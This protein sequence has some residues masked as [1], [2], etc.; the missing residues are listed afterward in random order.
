[1]IDCF[2]TISK[3]IG[4]I[5]SQCNAR[6]ECKSRHQC[7]EPDKLLLAFTLKNE[8]PKQE[9]A[10]LA[11]DPIETSSDSVSRLHGGHARASGK[12]LA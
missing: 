11:K 8:K 2:T 12:G 1:M 7:D 3:D 4:F 5:C 6:T 10:S 9:T